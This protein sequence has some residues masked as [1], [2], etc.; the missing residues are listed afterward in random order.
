MKRLPVAVILLAASCGT[1]FVRARSEP[2]K[3]SEGRR[4]PDVSGLPASFT[5]MAEDETCD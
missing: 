5:G 3:A 2:G 4:V 1:P